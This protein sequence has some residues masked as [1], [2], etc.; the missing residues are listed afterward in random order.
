MSTAALSRKRASPPSSPTA[1]LSK[2]LKR[3]SLFPIQPVTR[4]ISPTDI[5]I[6]LKQDST[7]LMPDLRIQVTCLKLFLLLLARM[8]NIAPVSQNVPAKREREPK[9][10]YREALQ[11]L[12][13]MDVL[14]I[15]TRKLIAT[16]NDIEDITK[17]IDEIM[18]A[19]AP[20]FPTVQLRRSCQ[21]FIVV[22]EER[23]ARLDPKR[24]M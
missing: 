6:L 19:E 9:V 23:L 21:D 1:S 17:D 8:F 15:A 4:I 24:G 11:A 13:K 20:S 12:K 14:G 22:Y 10:G 18:S 5:T 16:I 7:E 2:K 3:T